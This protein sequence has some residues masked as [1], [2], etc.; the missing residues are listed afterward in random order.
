M[1]IKA[2]NKYIKNE[3]FIE[4]GRP[5]ENSLNSLNNEEITIDI[6]YC[7]KLD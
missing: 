5:R 6:D 7:D 1:K 2:Q 4:D 3:A